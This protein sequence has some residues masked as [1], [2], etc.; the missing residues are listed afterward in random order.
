MDRRQL[1]GSAFGAGVLLGGKTAHG[2]LDPESA[3]TD[4]VI[5]RDQPA[6]IIWHG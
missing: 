3:A 4:V 6:T 1:L 5:E 2:F